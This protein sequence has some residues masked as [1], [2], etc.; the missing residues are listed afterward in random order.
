MIINLET[1]VKFCM[2]TASETLAT[3]SFIK[4]S[5]KE[6]R[7]LLTMVRSLTTQLFS[8]WTTTWCSETT[9][10]K[11]FGNILLSQLYKKMIFC[12]LFITNHSSFQDSS[13]ST[14][15][16]SGTLK[17]ML[18]SFITL[19][20]TLTMC[21]LMIL[22]RKTKIIWRSKLFWIRRFWSSRFTSWPSIIYST[23]ITCLKRRRYAFSIICLISVCLL[24]SNQVRRWN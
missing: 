20:G 15:S 22:V 4:L 14:T 13:C 2:P 8:I 12:H 16:Q 6:L 18:T 11:R 19:S 7:V 9:R 17:N 5:T 1:W 24:V 3:Q 23:C 10:M 21:S